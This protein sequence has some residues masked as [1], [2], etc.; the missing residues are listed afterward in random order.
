MAR[1]ELVRKLDCGRKLIST[2]RVR[3]IHSFD[4]NATPEQKKAQALKGVVEDLGLANGKL[5]ARHHGGTGALI[6]QYRCGDT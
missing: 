3:S 5:A 2:S 1:G 6:Q 4:P